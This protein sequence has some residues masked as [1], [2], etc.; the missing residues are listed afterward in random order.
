MQ[1]SMMTAETD[2]SSLLWG[3]L[4][5][6]YNDV[7]SSQW[8]DLPARLLQLC[9]LRYYLTKFGFSICLHLNRTM[10]PF[11]KLFYF[12][13]SQAVYSQ[14]SQ[15]YANKT[16]TWAFKLSSYFFN[17]VCGAVQYDFECSYAAVLLTVHWYVYLC[18]GYEMEIS[19]KIKVDMLKIWLSRTHMTSS[20]RAFH[21]VEMCIVWL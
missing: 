12:R 13:K 9:W 16:Q 11:Q 19:L 3:S 10:T 21:L 2:T 6:K 1:F 15:K 17:C 18:C 4:R 7:L 20:P 5:V 14:S 8:E